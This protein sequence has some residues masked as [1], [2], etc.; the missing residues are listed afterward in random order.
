[1]AGRAWASASAGATVAGAAANNAKPPTNTT[2]A[3]PK[4]VANR[5]KGWEKAVRTLLSGTRFPLFR[6]VDQTE[7]YR[8]MVTKWWGFGGAQSSQSVAFKR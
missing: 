5:A 4:A 1:M 7:L 6:R 8:P 3:A 2:A